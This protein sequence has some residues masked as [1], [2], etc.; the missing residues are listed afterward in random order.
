MGH[1][2]Q[3]QP[4]S[5]LPL[6]ERGENCNPGKDSWVGQAAGT[7]APVPDTQS[8]DLPPLPEISVSQIFIKIENEI[9]KGNSSY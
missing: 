8:S 4:G 3:P 7:T 2:R 9:L 6:H 5:P 1:L